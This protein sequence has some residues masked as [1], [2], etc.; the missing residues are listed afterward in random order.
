MI[1][2]RRSET[3][4]PIAKPPRCEKLSMPGV[5]IVRQEGCPR[6]GK[7]RRRTWNPAEAKADDDLDN[8]HEKLALWSVLNLPMRDKVT[9]RAAP[10]RHMSA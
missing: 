1:G 5:G 7:R 8:E 10:T 2:K 9:V 3:S 6:V 4:R